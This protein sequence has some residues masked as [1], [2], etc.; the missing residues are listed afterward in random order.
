MFVLAGEDECAIFL[1][2]KDFV[3]GFFSIQKK[4]SNMTAIFRALLDDV[5]C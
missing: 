3:K 1:V 4:D 5:G 2:Q